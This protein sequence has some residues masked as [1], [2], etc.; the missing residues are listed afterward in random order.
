MLLCQFLIA[1]I[2]IH[3]SAREVTRKMPEYTEKQKISIHTSAREVTT[4]FK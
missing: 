4:A 2:S 3:T 1:I